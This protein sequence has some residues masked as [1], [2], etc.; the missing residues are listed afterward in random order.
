MRLF[1]PLQRCER[2]CIFGCFSFTMVSL[3]QLLLFAN[4]PSTAYSHSAGSKAGLQMWLIWCSQFRY[5]SAV[6]R[7]VAG[8]GKEARR[9]R[10]M[11]TGNNVTAWCFVSVSDPFLVCS[12]RLCQMLDPG[13]ATNHVRLFWVCCAPSIVY[14]AII[15]LSVC[16]CVVSVPLQ[17]A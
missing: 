8:A 6:A 11:Q 3:R 7:I 17:T 5:N 10:R 4:F 15:F 13:V 12:V 14:T 1:H 16:L 9:R 2:C